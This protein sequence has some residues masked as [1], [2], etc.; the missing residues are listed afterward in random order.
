MNMARETII[1]L[2]INDERDLYEKFSFYSEGSNIISAGTAK[3]NDEVIGFLAKE[4]ESTPL[5]SEFIVQVRMREKTETG[6]RAAEDS[7]KNA[8]FNELKKTETSLKK[9]MKKS[10]ILVFAGIF[11]LALQQILSVTAPRFVLKEFL[12]VM[13]WVF[14]WKAIELLFFERPQYIKRKIRLRK[15]GMAKFVF[16]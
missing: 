12:L 3:I 10:V 11:P 16:I 2:F 1:R 7:I 6:Q 8:V 4:T 15:L 9:I 14:M 13:A 5:H